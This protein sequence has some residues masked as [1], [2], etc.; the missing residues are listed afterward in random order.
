MTPTERS[1]ATPAPEYASRAG[2][3]AEKSPQPP[4][5]FSPPTKSPTPQ[6][7]SQEGED[8]RDRSYS[9]NS[10][11]SLGSFPSP[12]NHFPIPPIP[13]SSS[14]QTG[15][16]STTSST[17][18]QSQESVT[19]P[20]PSSSSSPIQAKARKD[21]ATFLDFSSPPAS[22]S[23]PVHAGPDKAKQA[24]SM[25]NEGHEG[26]SK[27]LPGDEVQLV[28]AVSQQP[29]ATPMGSDN[30]G[31]KVHHRG[32][33]V[34]DTELD[35]RRKANTSTKTIQSVSPEVSK[36]VERSDS[37]RTSASVVAAMREKYSRN[38]RCAMLC[39]NEPALILHRRPLRRRPRRR[40]P[41]FRLAFLIS[42][43]D[44]IPP[45]KAQNR[46]QSRSLMRIA[47]EHPEI[48]ALK[49]TPRQASVAALLFLRR[50]TSQR[51][52]PPRS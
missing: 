11:A 51:I 23:V 29:V 50:T 3:P 37:N 18:P 4:T 25:S 20:S 42:P 40:F 34:D 49:R 26:A 14:R 46:R 31:P 15:S 43:L 12:P 1:L 10:I 13:T 39:S 9:V 45:H 36:T 8:S 48:S 52:L 32:E 24:V 16:Q 35:S 22:P 38:V 21:S 7:T 6:M 27:T 28:E 44:M 5:Y 47:R 17:Q 2:T 30:R 33:H 41:V 19:T